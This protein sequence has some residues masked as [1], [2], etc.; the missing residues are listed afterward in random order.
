M[1][2]NAMM[3]SGRAIDKALKLTPPITFGS[4]EVVEYE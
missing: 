3:A 2:T 4:E 1:P